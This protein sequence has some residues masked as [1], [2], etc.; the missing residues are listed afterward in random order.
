L[1]TG[2]YPTLLPHIQSLPLP[3]TFFD[4][5]VIWSALPSFFKTQAEDLLNPLVKK[6]RNATKVQIF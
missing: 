2:N 4:L 3:P 1:S 6:D 5:R